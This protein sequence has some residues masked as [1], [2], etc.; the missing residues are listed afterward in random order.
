M[1]EQMVFVDGLNSTL[2]V[3]VLVPKPGIN[4][5]RLQLEG[6]IVTS[7]LT[8]MFGLISLNASITTFPFTDCIGSITTATALSLRAS[9]DC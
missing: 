3:L 9:K 1:L 2:F 6:T 4:M 5:I 8:I 7:V